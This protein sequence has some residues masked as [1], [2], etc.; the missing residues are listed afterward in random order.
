MSPRAAF[1]FIHTS[2]IMVE[3]LRAAGNGQ[4]KGKNVSID[5]LGEYY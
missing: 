2:E 4:R 1:F 5:D 3:S